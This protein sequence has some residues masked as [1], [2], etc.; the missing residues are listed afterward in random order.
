MQKKNPRIQRHG[1]IKI[2]FEINQFLGRRFA[3][4]PSGTP[5]VFGLMLCYTNTVRKYP[6]REILQFTAVLQLYFPLPDQI[7]VGLT[8]TPGPIVEASVMERRY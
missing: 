1:D 6:S 7:F 3:Y 4:V 2:S 8:L 5:A